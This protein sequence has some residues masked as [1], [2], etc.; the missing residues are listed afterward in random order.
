MSISFRQNFAANYIAN[1][2]LALGLE[3]TLECLLLSQRHFPGP[4]L[5]VGCGDGLFAKILFADKIDTGIDLDPKEIACARATGAYEELICCP[6]AEI[7]K[8]AD[9]FATAF[10][11]SVL[12][13]IPE[14]PP[15]LNEVFRV[16]RPGGIFYFTVP[17]DDFEQQAVVTRMLMG[18]G[19]RNQ[20][21]S[22]RRWYNR[23]W[24]HF[25]AYSPDQWKRLAID[26]GFEVKEMVR[27]NSPAMTTRNDFLAPFAAFSSFL[28]KSTGRWVLVPSLRRLIIGPFAHRAE[29]EMREN[30]VGVNGS[31]VL[32]VAQKPLGGN[33]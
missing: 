27:Y 31:L 28:K 16:L 30:G 4:V 32:I 14:L 9:A 6:G 5:D 8:P 2:P 17:T 23:F 22:Y 1:T 26:A 24:R 25:H 3:R 11:N 12:E 20:A 29:R 7:P 21:S 19:L 13:H 10:S 33:A 15:V 18:M